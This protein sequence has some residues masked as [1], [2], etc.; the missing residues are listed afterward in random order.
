MLDCGEKTRLLGFMYLVWLGMVGCGRGPELGKYM[1]IHA[2]A[3]LQ[4]KMGKSYIN[5]SK[6]PGCV[7][8]YIL[9]SASISIGI[10]KYQL[11]S[12]DINQ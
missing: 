7:P 9:I 3:T 1:Q 10:N 2:A 6:G 12:I 11:V 5:M 8:T 4:G